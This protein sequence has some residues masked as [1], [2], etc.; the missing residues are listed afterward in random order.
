MD[1]VLLIIPRAVITIKKGIKK[2][3][4]EVSLLTKMH[5]LR[6][7]VAGLRG[8]IQVSVQKF[9]GTVHGPLSLIDL[10]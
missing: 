8:H 10:L 6:G 9:V 5:H 3:A 1:C 2:V 7:R 4:L